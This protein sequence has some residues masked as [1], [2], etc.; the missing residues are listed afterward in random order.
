MDTSN[1]T[2]VTEYFTLFII[3]NDNTMEEIFCTKP[4]QTEYKLSMPR[5]RMETCIFNNVKPHH[6]RVYCTR[7]KSN[8]M[9]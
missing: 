8:V 1:C 7:Q 9:L 4:Q 6:S 2:I 3:K 5:G